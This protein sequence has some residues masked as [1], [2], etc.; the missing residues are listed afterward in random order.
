MVGQCKASLL[1]IPIYKNKTYKDPTE[2]EYNFSK[3]FLPLS[4]HSNLIVSQDN[5]TSLSCFLWIHIT[6]DGTINTGRLTK[7]TCKTNKIHEK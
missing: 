2:H 6:V 7:I 3:F 1:P 4:T 5:Y